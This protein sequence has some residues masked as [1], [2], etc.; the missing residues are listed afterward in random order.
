MFY[1]SNLFP[2]QKTG[3]YTH[4]HTRVRIFLL[5]SDALNAHYFVGLGN[6]IAL[7]GLPNLSPYFSLSSSFGR[8]IVPPKWSVAVYR[9]IVTAYLGSRIFH[10]RGRR[11]SGE[12]LVRS[13]FDILP[14]ESTRLSFFSVE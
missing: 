12:V 8:K 2:Q 14:R 9:T 6:E 4:T 13:S 10:R 3:N 1:L 11:H 7:P 5:S